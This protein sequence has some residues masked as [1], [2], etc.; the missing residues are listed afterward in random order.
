MNKDYYLNP[1]PLIKPRINSMNNATTPAEI[2]LLIN[3]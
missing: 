2:F 1:N 3:A